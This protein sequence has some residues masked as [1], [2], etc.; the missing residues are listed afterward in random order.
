M[1]QWLMI[2]NFTALTTMYKK[3]AD[4]FTYRTPKGTEKQLD[5]ILVDRKHKYCGRD[6]EANDMIHMGSDHRSLR[7]NL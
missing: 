6:A 3:T 4:F 5:Y 1:K 7:Q 2:Q